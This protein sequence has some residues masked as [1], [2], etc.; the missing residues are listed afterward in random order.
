MAKVGWYLLFLLVLLI[1]VAFST[2]VRKKQQAS[3]TTK[4]R[5]L[6]FT[7][8]ASIALGLIPLIVFPWVLTGFFSRSFFALALATSEASALLAALL[9]FLFRVTPE[10]AAQAS[11]VSTFNVS[12]K[13]P[14]LVILPLAIFGIATSVGYLVAITYLYYVRP[15]HSPQAIREIFML[16]LAIYLAG[17]VV[18]DAVVIGLISSPQV[19]DRARHALFFTV[20]INAIPMGVFL[21]VFLGLIRINPQTFEFFGMG[22]LFKKWGMSRLYAPTLVLIG[23]FLITMLVPYAF[24]LERRRRREIENHEKMVEWID[25]IVEAASIPTAEH[26]ERLKQLKNAV[27]RAISECADSEPIVAVAIQIEDAEAKNQELDDSLKILQQPYHALRSEDLRFSYFQS[28][29]GLES[30]LDDIIQ[31][32]SGATDANRFQLGT[33]VA[34]QLR[35]QRQ[36]YERKMEAAEKRNVVAPILR[37]ATTIVGAIPAVVNVAH[38][39]LGTLDFANK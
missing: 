5:G 36:G 10:L 32:Y 19:P 28:M 20:L 13:H 4:G 29:R 26:I 18:Q 1:Y 11:V 2:Q 8:Q 14:L 9:F 7:N 38:R 21:T 23:F 31:S 39:L 3:L 34:E 24:G 6:F 35:F 30:K 16:N 27:T 33:N 22:E 12:Q 25:K 17:V 15:A 37:I